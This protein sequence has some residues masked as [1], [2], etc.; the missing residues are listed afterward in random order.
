MNIM[1]P[2]KRIPIFLTLCLALIVGITTT[3]AQFNTG[4][5]TK[6]VLIDSFNDFASVQP[7]NNTKSVIVVRYGSTE[8]DQK[9]GTFMYDSTSAASADGLN[10]FVPPSGVGRFLRFD[11]DVF[12]S[13]TATANRVMVTNGSGTI[14]TDNDITFDGSNLTVTGNMTVGGLATGSTDDVVIRNGSDLLQYRQ[15]N[16]DVWNLAGDLDSLGA[17]LKI[18]GPQISF[19][20][21]NDYITVA[22]SDYLT[23]STSTGI[24]AN[25]GTW[26]A[27][28]NTPLLTDGVGTSGHYYHVSAAGTQNFGSGAITFAAG[29][30]VS[31]D[32]SVWSHQT[33]D[34]LPASFS[35]WVKIGD[36]TNFY[37]ASRNDGSAVR[38]F[39]FGLNASDKLSLYLWTDNS[40]Y[41]AVHSSDA[42][43]SY[44]GQ[45]VHLAATY[46]GAGATS[47]NAFSAA[48]NGITLY[49]N[50]AAVSSTD[51]SAGTYLGM[52]NTV[53]DLWVGR[54]SS[55]YANGHV[56][57][58]K[59]FNRELTAAEIAE[60]MQGDLGFADEW[61]GALG[62]TYTS[63]FVGTANGWT[64]VN[65]NI[66]HST[67]IG[68]ESNALRLTLNGTTGGHYLQKTGVFTRGK[69]YR[70]AGKYYVPTNSHVDGI[71]F[72]IGTA[73]PVEVVRA[74]TPTLDSWINFSVEVVANA[75]SDTDRLLVYAL[76]GNS[77]TL[78]D[79]GANDVLYILGLVITEIGT[80]ADFR[81][82][83]LDETTGKLYDISSNAFVGVNSGASLVGRSV[84]VFE[85]GTWTPT[86][87]FGG[88]S[89]GITYTTQEGH[90]TREGNWVSVHAY[91]VLSNKGSDTGTALIAGLPFTARNT[92]ASSQSLSVGNMANAASLTS[93]V[94]AYATDNGTT[95]NLVDWGATGS[96]VLDNTNFGNTTSIS[97]TGKYQ[98]Q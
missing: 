84:P 46:E 44:E 12:L 80:L 25:Q 36:A 60:S 48:Q 45:W 58:I 79:P 32:G 88:G 7:A 78:T 41:A 89:T 15:I 39:T 83:Q 24:G 62:D 57:D 21:K 61:G 4:A 38:E 90:Y 85:V 43:T 34:D 94:T 47:G 40:N 42:L 66:A 35:A 70:I 74:A 97:I 95:I 59:I 86:V 55:S 87:T 17:A 5:S 2:F 8:G 33:K 51:I 23:F 64:A 9:G 13:K 65:G 68:G 53:R 26:S 16:P 91:I 73:G 71:Y 22:D 52:Q 92:T 6:L 29:D 14:S 11:N 72:A 1:K 37:I 3:Q 76:D 63:T 56:R 77:P 18:I 93:P 67:S 19:D 28:T 81:A 27:A 75:T 10:V 69:R 98:I 31:Y 54:S 49:V 20:G 82:E 96:A 50:G 30:V